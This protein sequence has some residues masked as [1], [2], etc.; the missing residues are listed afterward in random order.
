MPRDWV[1]QLDRG[2]WFASL[3]ADLRDRLLDAATVRHV[4]SGTCLF[5]LHDEFDGLH[6]VLQGAVE[7]CGQGELHRDAVL[8]VMAPPQW[9]GEVALFGGLARTHSTE[10]RGATTLLS[11]PARA[12]R[13]ILDAEPAHWQHLGRLL[14]E[15]AR[16][17]FRYTEELT[18]VPARPRLA[19]RLLA[20]SNGNGMLV[21]SEVLLRLHVSQEQLGAIV[22]LTRQ[23]ISSLLREFQ[24][25]GVIRRGYNEI[26]ILDLPALQALASQAP[27]RGG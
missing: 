25:L 14:A 21:D 9:F 17:L 15:K 16:A 6:C 12:I 18:Q 19:R 7:I 4:P 5:R 2:R 1:A 23:T 10:A 26:E 24:Q 11:V 13:S 8:I 22:A 3:P 20:M 27:D